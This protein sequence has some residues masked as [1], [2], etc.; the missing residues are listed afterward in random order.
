LARLEDSVAFSLSDL[1]PKRLSMQSA[2]EG[3]MK[4]LNQLSRDEILKRVDAQRNRDAETAQEKMNREEQARSFNRPEAKADFEYW[5]K[6]SYWTI[7]E[8]VALSLGREPKSALWKYVESIAGI[9]PFAAKFA[10]KRE[11]AMRAKAMG[12]LWDSTIPA[13]FLAWADR[14]KFEVAEPLV[15]AV[16]GL[17]QQIADW[18]TLYERQLELTEQAKSQ[19]AEKHAALVAAMKDHSESLSKLNNDYAG[20]L[21]QKDALATLKDERIEWLEARIESVQAANSKKPIHAKERESLLKLIIGMAIK[22]YGH[23]PKAARS[24]TAKEIAGDL[25][26]HG[27]ALDEDTVRKYLAEA[28]ELLPGGET[29]Q[30][31]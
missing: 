31:R 28:K 7:D 24:P 5:A 9:S 15:E 23:D 3:Y 14:M 1:D 27:I 30:N 6:M 10:A 11:L 16:R 19:A 20:L 17:G 12:Q 25:A 29:E 8:A 2:A 4:D 26:C 21:R 18:K 22:G 13:I